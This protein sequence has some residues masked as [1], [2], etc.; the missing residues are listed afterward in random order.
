MIIGLGDDFQVCLCWVVIWFLGF[1]FLSGFS[2]C[3]GCVLPVLVAFS[4]SIFM[5]NSC[6]CWKLGE[7]EAR[8]SI[9]EG[10]TGGVDSGEIR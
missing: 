5:W 2:E 7:G 8:E 9:S 1:C 4:V 3:V 6:W 10:S